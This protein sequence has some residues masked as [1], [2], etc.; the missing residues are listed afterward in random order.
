M[1]IMLKL[2]PPSQRRPPRSN[3]S[4]R[5]AAGLGALMLGVGI[6]VGAAIGPAPDSS[7]AG[8]V[9]VAVRLPA[10]IAALAA[11]DHGASTATAGRTAPGEPEVSRGV[12]TSATRT[13]AAG[14]T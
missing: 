10:L 2:S 13:H 8:G 7:L 12:G 1:R 11:G 6:A 9:D 5:F 14:A 4:R 3:P